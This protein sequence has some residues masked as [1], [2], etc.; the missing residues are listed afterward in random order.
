MFATL[1][2]SCYNSKMAVIATH[3]T[4]DLDGVGKGVEDAL[5]YGESDEL[6]LVKQMAIL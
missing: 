6:G 3:A 2:R 5:Q 4:A 1:C